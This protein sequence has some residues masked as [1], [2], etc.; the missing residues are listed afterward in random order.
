MFIN[1]GFGVSCAV[2]FEELSGGDVFVRAVG[3]EFACADPAVDGLCSYLAVVG[4][5]LDGDE[6]I[7][8]VLSV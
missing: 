6:V 2:V 8:G 3:C 4:C 1:R 7:H 5:L